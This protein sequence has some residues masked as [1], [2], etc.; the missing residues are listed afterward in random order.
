MLR[1]R[2]PWPCFAGIPS[3]SHLGKQYRSKGY[4]E[5][6][7]LMSPLPSLQQVP[8]AIIANI[9]EIVFQLSVE[10]AKYLTQLGGRVVQ[11]SWFQDPSVVFDLLKFVILGKTMRCCKNAPLSRAQELCSQN[12]MTAVLDMTAQSYSQCVL[13]QNEASLAYFKDHNLLWHGELLRVI[14]AIGG[15][16]HRPGVKFIVRQQAMYNHSSCFDVS[17][18]V[19]VDSFFLVVVVAG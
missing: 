18:W 8:P 1:R 17:Y 12:A 6:L 7:Q 3:L 19:D 14:L 2:Q 10:D 13:A 9:N 16:Y 11:N 15:A 4:H 5:K